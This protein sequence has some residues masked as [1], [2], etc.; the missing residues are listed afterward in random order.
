MPEAFSRIALL[1]VSNLRPRFSSASNVKEKERPRIY[2]MTYEKG[3]WIISE[4]V[5]RA[6]GELGL[7]WLERQWAEK[8]IRDVSISGNTIRNRVHDFN[9]RIMDQIYNIPG[10]RVNPLHI[11]HENEVYFSI[12]YSASVS[13]QVSDVIVEYLLLEAD[14]EKTLVFMGEYEK[15]FPYMIDLYCR[16]GGTMQEFKLVKTRWHMKEKEASQEMQGIFQNRGSFHPKRL[17]PEHTEKLLYNGDGTS[18][19]GKADYTPI[20]PDGGCGEIRVS[21]SFFESFYNRVVS[22]NIEPIMFY[23]TSDGI[24]VTNCIIIRTEEVGE[25]L[26]S[27]KKHF[28]DEA[29]SGHQNYILSVEDIADINYTVKTAT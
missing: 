15:N 20:C 23:A 7:T 24:D 1:K 4:K 16:F 2:L 19:N 18:F 10:A 17:S 12:E 29:R 8:G 25:L 5:D 21:S 11:W 3:S 28:D 27:L 14:F 26:K 6:L 22:P 13:Q 9:A